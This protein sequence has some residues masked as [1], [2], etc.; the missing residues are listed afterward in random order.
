MD[1]LQYSA[2]L[3]CLFA[4][5]QGIHIVHKASPRAWERRGVAGVNKVGIVEQEEN[6]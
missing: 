5:G 3:F 4:K 1:S 6:G 2:V